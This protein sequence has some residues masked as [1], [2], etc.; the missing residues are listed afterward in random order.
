MVERGA[1]IGGISVLTPAPPTIRSLL[2]QGEN[3]IRPFYVI[4]QQ[5]TEA[6]VK[7]NEIRGIKEI[8]VSVESFA[9]DIPRISLLR[10]IQL[11][12]ADI[13]RGKIPEEV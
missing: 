3:F 12:P 13:R 1:I 6:A 5:V 10:P 11:F 9:F 4:S 8:R 2:V 7:R